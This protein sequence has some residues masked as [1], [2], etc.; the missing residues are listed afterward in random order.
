MLTSSPEEPSLGSDE[1]EPE[2][3]PD[4]VGA[5]IGGGGDA[6]GKAV[7]EGATSRLAA[8]SCAKL[9]CRWSGRMAP[10]CF[11]RCRP[12]CGVSEPTCSGSTVSAMRRMRAMPVPGIRPAS[13]R[14]LA[15]CSIFSASSAK[16]P[17]VNESPRP[18]DLP[19]REKDDIVGKKKLPPR[20]EPDALEFRRFLLLAKSWRRWSGVRSCSFSSSRLGDHRLFCLVRWRRRSRTSASLGDR[21][22]DSCFMSRLGKLKLFVGSS[23]KPAAWDGLGCTSTESWMSWSKLRKPL[24]LCKLETLKVLPERADKLGARSFRALRGESGPALST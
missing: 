23:A 15:A 4:R 6:R 3:E 11:L 24:R 10:L 1:Y 8:E 5:N 17:P 22:I 9:T 2:Y 19:D 12:P 20:D 7:S 16:S 13:S 14:S 21:F 18:K